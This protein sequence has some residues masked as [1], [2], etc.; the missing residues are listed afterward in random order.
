[1]VKIVRKKVLNPTVTLLEVEAPLIAKKAR[2]GQ[3]IIF[4]VDENG[5]RIPLT[6]ADQNP[7]KGTVTI[8]FQKVGLSTEMLGALNEGDTILDFVGP[9][10]VPTELPEGA[11]SICVV[12]GG[13][14]C[15]IAYPQ[16]K[17]NHSAGLHVDVIAGF[18]SKDIVILEDEFKQSSDNFYLMTDDGSYGEKGFVTVKL[19]ELLESGKKYDAVIAIGPIPMM[20]FVCETAKPYGVPAI[21]SLNPLMIDGTGMCGCCRVTVN[22]KV[23]FACVDGPDFDGYGVDFDELMNRNAVYREQEQ[24]ERTGEHHTCRIDQ[25]AHSLIH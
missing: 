2:P 19:K 14:G 25:L 9:L 18:R 10:G 13:V 6:I 16:A 22:G 15:A 23:R 7:E 4:R 11:K 8:I 20:K 12:G 17:A 24:E 21:V 1:M 3:F 5:E